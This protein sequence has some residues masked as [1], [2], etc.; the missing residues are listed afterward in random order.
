MFITEEDY[1][2]IASD[3]L[4]VL[5]QSNTSNRLRAELRAMER[6]KSYLSFRYDIDKAFEAEVENRS[7]E[8]VG[9]VADIALYYMV[10]SLPQKM[11]YDIRKEQFEKA[12]KFL[13]TVQAGKA[14]MNLPE[15]VN[16]QGEITNSQIRYGS[17]DKNKYLW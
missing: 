17:E 10:L 5:K 4:N 13:E 7:F 12:I 9:L 6:V 14:S 3:A 1:I 16:E 15:H 11:G 2:Q 8:L